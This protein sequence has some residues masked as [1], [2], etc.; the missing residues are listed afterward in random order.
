VNPIVETYFANTSWQQETQSTAIW[1]NDA[2]KVTVSIA[3]DKNDQWQA[4]VKYQALRSEPG[5]FYHFAV[6]M[7]ANHDVSNVTV[8]WEDNTGLVMADKNIALVANTE[9][10]YEI[11]RVASN[12]AG[13]GIIVFD[14]GYAK[15]TDVIEIYG[16]VV[17]EVEAPEINLENGYYIIGLN[18]WT[19]YDLTADDK[20]EA[21]PGADG[22]YVITK[23]LADG[24]EFKVMQV[25]DNAEGG[26]FPGEA[27]NYH[28]DAN[29]AGSAKAI[30][31][32]PDYQGGADW[33][34]GC[35]FVA[36]NSATAIDNTAVDAKA[37]K[38]LRNG[39][40]LI[41]KGDKTYNIMGQIVK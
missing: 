33:H 16:I 18:G 23:A 8:K 4:Q 9:Y 37:E 21:N 28:V 6:K 13:N 15:A 39:M 24:N 30:Y 19:I 29:H 25:I 17:E 26:W 10:V 3:V 36:D 7:K 1:D 2:Q 40:I 34:A 38:I 41:I 5:K 14:F 31:F 11:E 27:G 35:I 12:A 32:R 22:E 20:F